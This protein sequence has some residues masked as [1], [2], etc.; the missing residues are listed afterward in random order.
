M[1]IHFLGMLGMLGGGGEG[2]NLVEVSGV[3]VTCVS[4]LVTVSIF[5]LRRKRSSNNSQE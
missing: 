1:F 3:V 2:I 5:E 4:V